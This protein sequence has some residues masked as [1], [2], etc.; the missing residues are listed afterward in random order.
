[1]LSRERGEVRDALS[2][3]GRQRVVRLPG[4]GLEGPSVVDAGG[5]RVCQPRELRLAVF[6]VG[7][8]VRALVRALLQVVQP[9]D[10]GVQLRRAEQDRDR[11]WLILLVERPQVVAEHAL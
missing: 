7:D 8:G 1:A 10:G 6:R 11:V 9:R 4:T 5:E 3:G 2:P